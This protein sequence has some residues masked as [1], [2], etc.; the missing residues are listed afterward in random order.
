MRVG[1]T[2]CATAPRHMNAATIIIAVTIDDSAVG[3]YPGRGVTCMVLAVPHIDHVRHEPHEFLRS[4]LPTRK[5]CPA[6]D[7]DATGEQRVRMSSTPAA[8]MPPSLS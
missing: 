2:I 3:P 1:V 4:K 5:P 8:A 7:T 6:E